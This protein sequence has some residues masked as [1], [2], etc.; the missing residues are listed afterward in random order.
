VQNTYNTGLYQRLHRKLAESVGGTANGHAQA[1][2]G[3]GA[4]LPD[5]AAVAAADQ[6]LAGM[7]G[8]LPALDLN[9][10]DTRY[11]TGTF[12]LFKNYLVYSIDISQYRLLFGFSLLYTDRVTFELLDSAA[13][14]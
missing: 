14:L 4:P 6:G 2:G 10:V 1:G 9:W 7:A 8:G 3:G 5:I 11:R 12:N 13:L